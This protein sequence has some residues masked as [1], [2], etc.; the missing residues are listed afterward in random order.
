MIK[1]NF[2][3]FHH[4]LIKEKKKFNVVDILQNLG[5]YSKFLT[6]KNN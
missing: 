6:K 5:F 3:C 4:L 2:A 1:S